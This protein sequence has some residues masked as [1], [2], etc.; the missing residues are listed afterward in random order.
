M[1]TWG[2]GFFDD[3]LAQDWSLMM[4]KS[5]WPR[6]FPRFMQEVKDEF[7]KTAD[8]GMVDA[9]YGV[10]VIATAAVVAS[11]AGIK[12]ELPAHLRILRRLQLWRPSAKLL[13]DAREVCQL[14]IGPKSEMSSMWINDES[15]DEW[16]SNVVTLID[17]LT[18]K[19]D[20]RKG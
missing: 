6:D 13:K 5:Y 11:M 10:C 16:R 8:E 18:K 17:E 19:I 9:M 14:S 12:V 1:G 15:E 20:L 4:M 7:A 2:S 3:D